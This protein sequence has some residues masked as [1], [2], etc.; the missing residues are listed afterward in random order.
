MRQLRDKSVA[1][2]VIIMTAFGSL[3]TAVD[4]IDGGA[5]HYLTKPID[6]D[7]AV[8]VVRQAVSASPKSC[9]AVTT[10]IDS[11]TRCVDRW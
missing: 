1:V 7:K 5:S 8:A 9:S 10:A 3:S 2:P 11:K 6:L 4:A